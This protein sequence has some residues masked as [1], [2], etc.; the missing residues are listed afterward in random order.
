MQ[1]RP[2]FA[3]HDWLYTYAGSEKV[4]ESILRCFPIERLFTLV[5]FL[6][7]PHRRFLR[8]TPVIPSFLQKMPFSRSQRRLYLPLMPLAVESL[9]VSEAGLIISSSAAIAKGVLTHGEQLHICYCHSPARYAWDLTRDYLDTAGGRGALKKMLA[10]AVFHYFRLWDVASTP[11]VDHFIANSGYTAARLRRFYGRESTVIYPPVD[12]ERFPVQESKEDFFV[13]VSRLVPYKKVELIAAACAQAGKKLLV[14]GEGPDLPKIKAW[15]R[16]HI[17][18]LGWQPDDVVVDL[19][20][21][22]RAFIFAAREE[23]GIAGVEAQAA[24]TP[25]IAFGAGGCL[26]TIKGIFPG[27]RP[28]PGTTGVF[29]REQTVPSVL[30][31]LDWFD[32]HRDHLEPRA[33]RTNATRFA[34][35]HFEEEL[36]RFVSNCWEQFQS[37]GKTAKKFPGANP[38]QKPRN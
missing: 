4:L 3:V 6:P 19:V 34:R 7:G 33:C 10:Q 13:T 32:R 35:P 25:V 5:D 23:F 17:Q 24:G 36:K 30:E 16:E 15:Q 28:Q 26:E 14:I 12:I 20:R 2:I 9:D 1:D 11:R 29:F 37:C 27:Q 18:V 38:L 21:R 22:A 8:G 31:A